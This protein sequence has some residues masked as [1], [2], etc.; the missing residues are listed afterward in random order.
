MF[1][2]RR[3]YSIARVLD[4]QRIFIADDVVEADEADDVSCWMCASLSQETLDKTRIDK[5]QN[6]DK[7]IWNNVMTS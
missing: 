5:V 4:F 7:Y 6:I 1:T 2:Q 3:G